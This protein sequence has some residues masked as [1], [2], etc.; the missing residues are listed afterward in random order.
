MIT[1]KFDKNCFL[2]HLIELIDY[3][4]DYDLKRNFIELQQEFN[5]LFLKI[6]SYDHKI[7]K[8]DNVD[9]I[10][11]KL[12]LTTVDMDELYH[13]FLGIRNN[14]YELKYGQPR[15]D[16]FNF[17]FSQPVIISQPFET[18]TVPMGPRK[19]NFKKLTNRSLTILTWSFDKLICSTKDIMAIPNIV[20]KHKKCQYISPS[21][22]KG[23][24]IIV[25][26]P[27]INI[28]HCKN[29]LSNIYS[30]TVV[31]K[32]IDYCDI[33][34]PVNKCKIIFIGP[35]K[36]TPIKFGDNCGKIII[37]QSSLL[38]KYNCRE[39]NIPLNLDNQEFIKFKTGRY[40]HDSSP[41]LEIQE[42]IKS[43]STRHKHLLNTD[44]E[45]V[46]YKHGRYKLVYTDKRDIDYLISKIQE[47]IRH[48][49]GRY[50]PLLNEEDAFTKYKHGRYK[51]RYIDKQDINYLISKIEEFIVRK[52]GRYKHM[53]K[54]EDQEFIKFKSGRYKII[55][56][57]N[58]LI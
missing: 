3:K 25:L 52:H 35:T 28:E 5:R 12:G 13:D 14:L 27:I 1:Q 49:H 42:F 53:L 56:K 21:F 45:F 46:K 11:K 2:D 26:K 33:K 51:L 54:L 29:L 24:K 8:D 58:L 22:P 4:Q 16:N 50:K 43:K 34:L 30:N 36:Y 44:D 39:N 32:Y 40:K 48:K 47:F 7:N 23:K 41:K 55:P 15:E 18:K 10:A 20:P 57:H 6:I 31:P 19:R 17:S 37:E 9:H 38:Q